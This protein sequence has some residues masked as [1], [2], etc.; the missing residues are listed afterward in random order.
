MD[1]PGRPLGLSLAIVLSILIFALL[2]LLQAGFVLLLRQ[3]FANIEFLEEGGAYGG[4]I[5]GISDARLIFS[6]VSGLLFLVIGVMAWRGKPQIIR[7]VFVAAV[8]VITAASIGVSLLT[9]NAS[10][11]IEQGIDSSGQLGDTL[12]IFQM[13]VS[14]LIAAYVIWYTNRG[15]ARA[16]YRGYYLQSSPEGSD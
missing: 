12:L 11:T 13:A 16:F 14:V 10:A 5:D 1:K 3:Q 2:P 9:L 15:P 6:S 4:S 7:Y 8:I